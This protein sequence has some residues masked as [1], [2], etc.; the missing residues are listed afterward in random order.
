MTRQDFQKIADAMSAVLGTLGQDNGA[1]A[2]QYYD[3]LS[4]ELKK[5]FPNMDLNKFQQEA[6]L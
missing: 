2:T 1:L 4:V 6:G 5:R 3:L